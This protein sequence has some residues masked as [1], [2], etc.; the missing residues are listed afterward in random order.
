M[1]APA[2][3]EY[4]PDARILETA[5]S[6]TANESNSLAALD[7]ESTFLNVVEFMRCEPHKWLLYSQQYCIQCL[8]RVL[9]A[10]SSML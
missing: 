4:E 10:C 7:L 9:W 5:T 3:E 1:L 2:G 8:L 6:L